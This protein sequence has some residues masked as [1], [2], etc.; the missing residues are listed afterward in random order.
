[1]FSEYM[2]TPTYSQQWNGVGH[3]C[4]QHI[5]QKIKDFSGRNVDA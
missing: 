1:M 3:V 4:P 2:R 5:I